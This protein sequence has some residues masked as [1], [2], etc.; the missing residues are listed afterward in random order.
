[1]MAAAWVPLMPAGMCRA[2]SSGKVMAVAIPVAARPKASPAAAMVMS[3]ATS[4]GVR[5]GV[6]RTAGVMVLC[7]NSP[8]TES[9]PASSATVWASPAIARVARAGLVP[10]VKLVA[11]AVAPVPPAMRATAPA[12]SS[13]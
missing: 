5:R 3:L 8:V 9:A 2:A 4:S 7:R 6:I 12:A 13:Q 10:A 11:A 1:M